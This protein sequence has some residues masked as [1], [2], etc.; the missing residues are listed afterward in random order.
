MTPDLTLAEW[1]SDHEL[2]VRRRVDRWTDGCCPVPV[3]LLRQVWQDPVWR[4]TLRATVVGDWADEVGGSVALGGFLEDI[5]DDRIVLRGID[6]RTVDVTATELVFPH[7]DEIPDV[8]AVRRALSEAKREP[9]SGQLARKGVHHR[10]GRYDRW[11]AV[12]P[13]RDR[14]LYAGLAPIAAPTESPAPQRYPA[15]QEVRV[16]LYRHPDLGDRPI[17]QLLTDAESDGADLCAAWLGCA[18]PR[19]GAPLTA[20]RRNPLLGFPA[21]PLRYDRIT[22][23]D[24]IEG[25]RVL[26]VA[27]RLSS[28]GEPEQALAELRRHAAGLP[29]LHQASFWVS[30]AATFDSNGG[31]VWNAQHDGVKAAH[32]SLRTAVANSSLA[33][34]PDLL[35]ALAAQYLGDLEKA[36][37]A[38]A[39]RDGADAALTAYRTAALRISPS[40]TVFAALRKFATAAGRDRLTEDVADLRAYIDHHGEIFGI[41]DTVLK[42]RKKAITQLALTD[43]HALRAIFASP[44]GLSVLDRCGVL[45]T[46]VKNKTVV[47]CLRGGVL[48]QQSSATAWIQEFYSDTLERNLAGHTQCE[49][50]VD[51]LT[52]APA[53]RAVNA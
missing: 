10:P 24:A 31:F 18:E 27:R 2:Q 28:S 21:W 36:C 9:R 46:L 8:S 19:I 5:G 50:I 17:A 4:T 33:S 25:L 14:Q 53:D 6:G 39:D 3:A 11:K 51:L 49:Q 16:H 26:M 40:P 42:N 38:L 32:T 23:S 43:D 30:A 34:D 29:V 1:L 37:D 12:D 35:Y 13:A 45:A 47:Q 15:E 52:S 22:E 20:A 41:S 48:W 44:Y 7:S